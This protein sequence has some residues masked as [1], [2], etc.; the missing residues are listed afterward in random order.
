MKQYFIITALALHTL[1]SQAVT[2]PA[3]QVDA[4]AIK[5]AFNLNG[6]NSTSNLH[7]ALLVPNT[8]STG[9]VHS[10][11]I[12]GEA[13]SDLAGRYGYEY[14]VDLS[15]V[16]PSPD[17]GC[18]TN[19]VRA[20][21][22]RV[23]VATNVITCRTG[24]VD[25]VQQRVCVTNQ[26]PATNLVVCL[27]NS[28]PGTNVQ[29]CFTNA[30]GVVTCTT[31][32]FPATNHVI[33]FTNRIPARTIVTCQT[34][35][36]NPGSNF[37]HCVTNRVFLH[38]NEVTLRTNTIPC[39]GNAPGVAWI[40]IPVGRLAATD[41][42]SNGV[43]HD[44]VY[45]VTNGLPNT[46]FPSPVYY[47]DGN[48]V[49]RFSPPLSPGESSLTVGFISNDPPTGA[50]ARGE[51]SNGTD[52]TAMVLASHRLVPIRCDFNRLIKNLR[53]LESRDLLGAT[54]QIKRERRATLLELAAMAVEA[55]Q[56][57][58]EADVQSA[59][60]AIS[61]RTDG[62]ADGWVAASATKKISQ[63]IKQ[64][65]KCV[66]KGDRDEGEDEDEDEDEDHDKDDDDHSGH[67]RD[68]N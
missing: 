50:N 67:R 38:T 26:I 49:L 66:T 56:A 65:V 1:G 45:V 36:L 21:T 6:T 14:T 18:V 46:A 19:I 40:R 61:D 64:V 39:P 58:N 47:S 33:C 30:A 3:V 52:F 12:V 29:R 48:I 31:N 68:R 9:Y 28:I 4:N 53:D 25:V 20:T 44:W 60:E 5:Y 17:T 27:T 57:G 35:I 23:L 37:V 11:V 16:R 59:L 34:N 51:L 54:T 8:T 22:N 62:G 43:S 15:G 63:A 32:F 55:A 2:L 10:T 42:D 24:T 7:S 41:L 13:G